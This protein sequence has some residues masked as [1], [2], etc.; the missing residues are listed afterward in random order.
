M[1]AFEN[2][3]YLFFFFFRAVVFLVFGIFLEFLG[4]FQRIVLQVDDKERLI[5]PN[6]RAE[7]NNSTSKI[8]MKLTLHLVPARRMILRC[9]LMV[10]LVASE[11]SMQQLLEA[12]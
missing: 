1:S 2:L 10:P 6:T 4:E 12:N 8:K 7:N 5:N 11:L 9:L 3:A